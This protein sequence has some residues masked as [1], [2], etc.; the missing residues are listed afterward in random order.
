MLVRTGL[1]VA[2]LLRVVAAI[3]IRK[4]KQSGRA[5]KNRS[6]FLCFIVKQ[7]AKNKS[8]CKYC[9]YE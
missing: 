1:V 2:A 8:F 3:I 9:G 4:N 5:V 6:S 7:N